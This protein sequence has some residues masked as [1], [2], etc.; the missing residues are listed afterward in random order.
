MKVTE[1]I[2]ISDHKALQKMK[3]FHFHLEYIAKDSTDPWIKDRLGEYDQ[4]VLARIDNKD[5]F[6]MI[7]DKYKG[8]INGF[9]HFNNVDT[10]TD[11]VKSDEA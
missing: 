2:Y 11:E 5:D 9:E 1:L 7:Y 10:Q 6:V 8:W 3:S 4:A